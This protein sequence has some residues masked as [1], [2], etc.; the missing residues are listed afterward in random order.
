MSISSFALRHMLM[1]IVILPC[2]IV[3]CAE[4]LCGIKFG[5]PKRTKTKLGNYLSFYYREMYLVRQQWNEKK[6]EK[7]LL[8]ILHKNWRTHDIKQCAVH[9]HNKYVFIPV[10]KGKHPV[11]H[12]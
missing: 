12:Y 9:I 6:K 4:L 10:D 11:A 7:E 5:E 2:N 3:R 1:F 8:Y